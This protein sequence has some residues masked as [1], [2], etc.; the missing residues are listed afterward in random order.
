[1]NYYSFSLCASRINS[2][3]AEP[4][5][6]DGLKHNSNNN[7]KREPQSKNAPIN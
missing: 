3:K 5:T 7:A 4:V 1:M 6:T 2:E